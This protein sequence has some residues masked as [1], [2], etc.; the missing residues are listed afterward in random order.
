M[1]LSPVDVV[2]KVAL[3]AEGASEVPPNTNSGPFV[4]RV[5]KGVGLQKGQPWCAAFVYN[6]GVQALGAQ[7]PLPQTGG[8]QVLADY[9]KLHGV[10]TVDIEVG[11]VFLIWHPELSR[12]AHTGFIVGPN[13]L[14]LS[15]NTSGA[16]SREGWLVGRRTWSFTA[17]DRFIR[18]SELVR[19]P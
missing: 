11:D 9:A 8:C 12:F 18:W 4:E 1:N 3:E 14:T 17:Q 19:I 16:G 15:G 10:L 7:W 6:V 13:H 2:V 5:L